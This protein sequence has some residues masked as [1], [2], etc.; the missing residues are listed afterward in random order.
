MS[1]I[2]NGLQYDLIFMDIIMPNLDGVSA[3][4]A[5]RYA[6]PSVP[7]IALTANI[8]QEDIQSYL[9]CGQYLF[10]EVLPVIVF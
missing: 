5:I 4:G 10:S 8:R 2:N 7:I 6:I 1:K 9:Q 3:T